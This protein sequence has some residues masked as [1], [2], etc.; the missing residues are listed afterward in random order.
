MISVVIP[1]I[2]GRENLLEQTVAG[3]RATADVEIIVVK[4]RKSCGEGWNAGASKASGDFL[5][6]SADDL[7]PQAGWADAGIMAAE[8]GWWPSPRLL[9]PDG[10][11]QSDGSMGGGMLLPEHRH[12]VKC[13]SSPFPFMET[14]DWQDIGPC[15]PLHYYADDYLAAKARE[16]DLDVM[17]VP[18]YCFVHLGGT[19]GRDKVAARAADDQ[20]TFLSLIAGEE[21]L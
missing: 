20:E 16:I 4:N 14:R 2:T 1:T 3:Y 6:F 10:T 21:Q 13:V 12:I 19:L 11:I 15:P 8:E 18:T 17:A 5:H 7:I 9:D